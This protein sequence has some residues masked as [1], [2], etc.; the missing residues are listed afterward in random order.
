MPSSS[1]DAP[2]FILPTT[3]RLF[4]QCGFL[5]RPQLLMCNAL[6]PKSEGDL[7]TSVALL[8]FPTQMT[9]SGS[10]AQ[11]RIYE[12]KLTMM[13]RRCMRAIVGAVHLG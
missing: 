12:R 11:T 8:S 1:D 5:A 7:S 3:L 4:L 13:N 10:E 6:L 2:S 9:W